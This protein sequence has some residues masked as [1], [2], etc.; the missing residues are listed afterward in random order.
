[1][2]LQYWQG[3]S[4]ALRPIRP[5]DAAFFRNLDDEY[6]RNVDA[7]VP[8]PLSDA[9]L[10]S[11]L[12]QQQKA[13][14]DDAIR[15]MADNKD[16]ETVGTIHTYQ[17]HRR[18]GTFKYGVA[19]APEHRGR[20]YASEMII[21]ILRYYFLQL[22]Y[23]KATPHVYAF[24]EASVRLHEKLGFLQEGRLRNMVYMDGKYHDEIHFGM[25]RDEFVMKYKDGSGFM[26]E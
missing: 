20:K 18:N 19:V 25:T 15:L 12:E 22:G 14:F 7:E 3:K 1:M 21:M 4:V 11:W 16:G 17:C 13:R 8:F 9:R 26:A 6:Y 5:D 24:N 23:Q 2:P 10:S